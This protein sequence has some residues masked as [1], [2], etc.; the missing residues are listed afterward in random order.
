MSAISGTNK[1]P[2]HSTVHQDTETYKSCKPCQKIFWKGRCISDLKM[3]AKAA[4]PGTIVGTGVAM[5]LMGAIEEEVEHEKAKMIGAAAGYFVSH[6]LGHFCVRLLKSLD[7]QK[8]GYD[9]K[10]DA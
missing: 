7:L 3:I 1:Q 2:W 9:K 8:D 5:L 10:N 4:I 6:L